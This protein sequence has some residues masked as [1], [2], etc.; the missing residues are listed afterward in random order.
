MCVVVGALDVPAD[1]DELDDVGN[2][3]DDKDAEVTEESVIETDVDVAVAAVD[4]NGRVDAVEV[5][6]EVVDDVV[7]D[8]DN[9]VIDIVDTVCGAEL[10]DIALDVDTIVVDEDKVVVEL[11]KFVVEGAISQLSPENPELHVQ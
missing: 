7:K 11:A 5:E 6:S 10:D 3:V 8:E 9:V 4:D 2:A 1:V